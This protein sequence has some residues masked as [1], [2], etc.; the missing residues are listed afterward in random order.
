MN[1]RILAKTIGGLL[2]ILGF[3]I[4]TPGIYAL[5]WGNSTA[6]CFFISSLIAIGLGVILWLSQRGYEAEI[7]HRTGFAVVTF[8]W[9]SA[10]LLGSLPYYLSGTLPSYIDAFFESTSGFSGTGSS[11][12]LDIEATDKAILLWRSMTQWLGGMGIIVFFIAILPILGV[13]GVQL[14]RAE[15]T[16]PSKDKITPRVRETAKK[17]WLLY[18]AFTATLALLLIQAGM[19]GYDAVNHAFTTLSTGGFSTKAAGIAA[20]NNPLIEYIII[21]F[22]LL[23]SINFALHYRVLALRDF[24]ALLSTELKWYLAFLFA[25]TVLLT[26]IV[27][28]PSYNSFFEAFRNALFTIVCTASSTGFTNSDYTVW[29]YASF[30]IIILMMA[31]GGM[32]GSTAGGLKCVRV[33]TAIK[34]LV[35]ELKQIVHPSAILTVKVNQHTL[36]SNIIRAIWSFI[37][38]YLMSFIGLTLVFTLDEIDIL[39]AATAAFS[40]LSNIGPG[41]GQVGPYDNFAFFPDTSKLT[42]AIGMLLGRLEFYTVLVI[43]TP[44]FWRK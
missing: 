42:M 14:Y 9:L 20:F 21:L 1:I 38:L 40:A 15:I 29:P 18:V 11:V 35:L 17:L 30:T 34:Q 44:E 39:T 2:A 6:A 12:L 27:W 25:F 32:S 28:G 33:L 31:M 13:G 8:S 7:N 5:F 37:F 19:S 22:M 23:S 3:I 10:C 36:P 4:A 43:F 16:G 41:L 26:G 24:K